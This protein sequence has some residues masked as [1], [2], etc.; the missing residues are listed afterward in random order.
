M[1][2]LLI[3]ILIVVSSGFGQNK[4]SSAE[5]KAMD[6]R[7]GMPPEP[8][9]LQY[10]ATFDQSRVVEIMRKPEMAVIRP[11]KPTLTKEEK[12]ELKENEKKIAQMRSPNPEDIEK[13]KEFLSQKKTGLFRLFPDLGCDAFFLLKTDGECK[14]TI[15]FSWSY[16][17]LRK[18]YGNNYF[19]DLRLKD[20]KLA[21]D[22]FL[23]Q[24]F[25]VSLGNVDLDSLNV[26][27][28]GAKF[29]VEF[30]PEIQSRKAKE[31][32]KTLLNIVDSDGFSYG[33]VVG[34]EINN[35]YLIRVIA[36]KI[37]SLT[38]DY[39][40][41]DKNQVKEKDIFLALDS[42]NRRDKIIAFKIIRKDSDGNISILWKELADQDSPR[43][44]FEKKEKPTDFREAYEVLK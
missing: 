13:F 29:L 35:T 7:N 23:E 39:L 43:L 4:T 3:L 38:K 10:P 26:Q 37:T 41:S 31:Q 12:D 40:L 21:V 17:F 36:Y 14:N 32:F 25:I 24:N 2:K 27:T 8:N 6:N 22:G 19:F 42:D 44:K 11:Q 33:K 30:K 15:P 16:S 18:S 1:K 34:S 20:G 9:P 5:R 28:K